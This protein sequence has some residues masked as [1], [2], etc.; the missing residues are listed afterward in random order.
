M[1]VL[2]V[3][4]VSSQSRSLWPEDTA[5]GDIGQKMITRVGC[6]LSSQCT[7]YAEFVHIFSFKRV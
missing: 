1:P 4:E 3:Y 5:V 2:L 7:L 6:T